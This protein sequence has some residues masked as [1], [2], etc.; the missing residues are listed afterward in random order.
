MFW[1]HDHPEDLHSLTDNVKDILTTLSNK[2][3][4][5]IAP[6]DELNSEVASWITS[7]NTTT[8][9]SSLFLE[10]K[11]GKDGLSSQST[12][13]DNIEDPNSFTPIARLLSYCQPSTS[14][15]NEVYGAIMKV[16]N[17]LRVQ[18]LLKK[19]LF[20]IDC[21]GKNIYTHI[22]EVQAKDVV[23]P[24]IDIIEFVDWTS[25]SKFVRFWYCEN[26]HLSSILRQ[27]IVKTISKSPD[28]LLSSKL[29]EDES[30]DQRNQFV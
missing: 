27:A 21:H 7:R 13:K 6:K 3:T 24:T 11:V 23:F 4:P 18:I 29:F 1:H 2:H 25:I 22:A 16:L 17:E 15:L 8:C 10:D 26:I 28:H 12:Y 19:T 14:V 20:V 30:K 9:L 5:A